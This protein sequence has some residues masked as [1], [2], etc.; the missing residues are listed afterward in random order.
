MQHHVRRAALFD[1]RPFPKPRLRPSATSVQH[2]QL[3]NMLALHLRANLT[4]TRRIAGAKRKTPSSCSDVSVREGVVDWCTSGARPSSRL[5]Q[6][7]HPGRISSARVASTQS[8][9]RLVTANET[10]VTI[11]R[12]AVKIS[13]RVNTQTAEL[14]PAV[15]TVV[16]VRK[17]TS[18]KL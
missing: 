17:I 3:V 13:R 1:R 14:F 5:A 11:M 4:E 16:G 10:I 9:M 18:C 7:I 8:E 2:C 15:E 6:M 12:A